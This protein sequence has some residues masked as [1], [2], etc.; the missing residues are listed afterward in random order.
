MHR[1]K[2]SV[3]TAL[4]E[5]YITSVMLIKKPT[6]LKAMPTSQTY[7]ATKHRSIA[8]LLVWFS[9]LQTGQRTGW[10]KASPKW[11]PVLVPGSSLQWWLLQ[12]REVQGNGKISHAPWNYNTT[13]RV[14]HIL[15]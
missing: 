10:C 7:L 12:H 6:Q 4:I 13:E 8:G 1:Q 11:S 3:D 5:R 9:D 14:R 2:R 15:H